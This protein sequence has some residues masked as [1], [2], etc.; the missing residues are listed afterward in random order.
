VYAGTPE[1][2]TVVG[3]TTGTSVEVP[4]A[5]ETGPDAVVEAKRRPKGAIKSTKRLKVTAIV[6]IEG[7]PA[8]GEVT[9]T[10]KGVDKTV[11]LNKNGKAKTKVGPFKKGT[12]TILVS[13]GDYSDILRF[14]VR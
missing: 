8:A 13:Y 9:F 3:T 12:H 6:S 2:V 11:E 1:S 7:E 5:F 4:V 14:K 10:G